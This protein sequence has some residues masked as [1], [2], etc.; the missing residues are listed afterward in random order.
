[1]QIPAVELYAIIA[2]A[3]SKLKEDFKV[4]LRKKVDLNAQLAQEGW[5]TE[6]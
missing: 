5:S 2:E 4:N 6:K 3:G 1:M